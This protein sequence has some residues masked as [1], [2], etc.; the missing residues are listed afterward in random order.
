MKTILR[1]YN[2]YAPKTL[3]YVVRV[4]PYGVIFATT[5]EIKSVT[6]EVFRK[7]PP[8]EGTNYTACCLFITV[9]LDC[10]ADG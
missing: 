10:C 1:V 8:P 2:E 9:I 3:Q 6:V 5:A 4:T 7:L